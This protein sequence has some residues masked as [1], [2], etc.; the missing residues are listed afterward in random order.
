MKTKYLL[1]I[2][3]VSFIGESLQQCVSTIATTECNDIKF[4]KG[5]PLKLD[6]YK[7]F[8]QFKHNG[9]IE[10]EIP[11]G[12]FKMLPE[13]TK[14]YLNGNNIKRL[15]S[16]SFE[17]LSKLISLILSD[18][19]I[20]AVASGTFNECDRLKLLDLSRNQI[21]LIDIAAFANLANS[22]EEINLSLNLL[23]AIP[24]DVGSLRALKILNLSGNQI[25][26][27]SV[28]MFNALNKVVIINLESNRINDLSNDNI[29]RGLTELK[30]LNLKD[31][32][33]SNLNVRNMLDSL[34]NLKIIKLNINNFKCNTLN[35]VVKEFQARKVEVTPGLFKSQHVINGISCKV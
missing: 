16:G 15:E 25:K 5:R 20:N 4:I 12:T 8:L 32:Q 34:K 35:N 17:G 24:V 1:F 31:N 7:S 6:F 14:L 23:D 9:N 26:S 19:R 22:L 11:R 30:E 18:N 29:W 27:I 2:V 33:L 21:Q 13:L 28:N 3:L 10:I